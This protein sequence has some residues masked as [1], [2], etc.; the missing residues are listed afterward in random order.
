MHAVC[1]ARAACSVR[2]RISI[3]NAFLL[4]VEGR[5]WLRLQYLHQCNCEHTGISCARGG[6]FCWH[7][8][9]QHIPV[10]AGDTVGG[11]PAMHGNHDEEAVAARQCLAITPHVT[12]ATAAIPVQQ[13]QGY[14]CV[15]AGG[16]I[17][18][19]GRGCR[20]TLA[21]VDLQMCAI[22]A[23]NGAQV[24]LHDTSATAAEDGIGVFACG[25]GT[26]VHADKVTLTEGLLGVSVQ[27]GARFS[28]K[29]VTITGAAIAALHACGKGSCLHVRKGHIYDLGKPENPTSPGQ[30]APSSQCSG[31]GSLISQDAVCCFEDT[32][33][34]R[35]AVGVEIHSRGCGTLKNCRVHGCSGSAV[36]VEDAQA[37]L[38]DCAMDSCGGYGVSLRRG[39]VQAHGCAVARTTLNSV[40]LQ[41]N[42]QAVLRWCTLEQ[43]G[44]WSGL[45]VE[46]HGSAAKCHSCLFH[47]NQHCGVFVHSR[48]AAHLT[49]CE[50]EGN[51]M[52]GFRVH[53]PG[54]RLKLSGCCAKDVVAYQRHHHGVLE[55]A[56]CSPSGH[57]MTQIVTDDGRVSTGDGRGSTGDVSVTASCGEGAVVEVGQAKKQKKGLFRALV[58]AFDP[59][60]H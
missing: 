30:G 24:W 20:L 44:L 27:G 4:R 49:A 33:F 6:F 12:L 55:C 28:G 48:G 57:M 54:A 35:C 56:N 32:A 31:N 8:R 60:R 42:S 16:M 11:R 1:W 9:T 25:A 45:E 21:R 17:V 47:R 23:L 19:R 40:H 15:C 46:G 41:E 18:C 58:R 5:L 50:T 39:A 2:C 36:A 29:F 10:T 53:G 3:A 52:S 37:E 22:I 59:K 7:R 38:F 13:I 34:E 26:A 51:G 43:S 14:R